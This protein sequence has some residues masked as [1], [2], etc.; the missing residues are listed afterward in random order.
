MHGSESDRRSNQL[1][2]FQNTIFVC[3]SI[4]FQLELNSPRRPRP[5]LGT[6]VVFSIFLEVKDFN[7]KFLMSFSLSA[8]KTVSGELSANFVEYLIRFRFQS[9]RNKNFKIF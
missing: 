3:V 6:S 7:S 1:M 4:F 8:S 9:N 5:Q 2:M